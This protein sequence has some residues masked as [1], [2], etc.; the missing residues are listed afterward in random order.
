[1]KKCYKKG[2]ALILA[3]S[4]S[5][6]SLQA[7]A[8]DETKETIVNEDLTITE[9]KTTTSTTT[10]PET[11]NITVIVDISKA[12]D[13]VT[14]AGVT[15]DRDENIVNESIV[16]RDGNLLEESWMEK[17]TEIKEWEEDI[18]VG[19]EKQPEISVTLN[20]GETTKESETIVEVTGDIKEDDNDLEYDFT[21]TTTDRTVSAKTSEVEVKV[22]ENS[23]DLTSVKPDVY[24]GKK[25]VGGV[26]GKNSVGDDMLNYYADS[27]KKVAQPGVDGFD[28]QHVGLG[29]YSNYN[30]MLVGCRYIVY[31]R[32][33]ET[34]EALKD[35]EGN[36]IIDEEA[37]EKKTKEEL[38]GNLGWQAQQFSLK[39]TE[40]NY[41]YAYCVDRDTGINPGTWYKVENLEDSDYYAAK[42]SADHLHAIVT[43]GYWGRNNEADE[44]GNFK[45][46]SLKNIKE[47]LKEAVKNGDIDDEITVTNKNGK[48][49]TFKLSEIIDG[50]TEGEAL[51]VTQAPMWIVLN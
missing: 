32:N 49:G 24:D 50:L 10:D 44:E 22:N 47:Q 17:G 45:K 51:N 13:G 14:D 39:D 46:G 2:L 25:D 35:A 16:D 6:A 36:Y 37:T 30:L 28:Y 29:E 8:I 19:D 33:P 7:F 31:Q 41:Y 20:P 26:G 12:T 34:G 9:V 1:M 4:M 42:D 18:K 40:G 48:S 5:M 21:T 11:G 23:T 3:A 15:V 43:N 38:N 27:A